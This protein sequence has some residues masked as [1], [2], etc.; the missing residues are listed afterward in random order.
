MLDSMLLAVG[1]KGSGSAGQEG[2]CFMLSDPEGYSEM[3]Q[4]SHPPGERHQ[5]ASAALEC[6][7][8]LESDNEKS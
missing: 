3:E 2:S 7:S 4:S 5:A 6:G 1:L 8:D